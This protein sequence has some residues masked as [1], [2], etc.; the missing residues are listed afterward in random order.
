MRWKN[1]VREVRKG[2]VRVAAATTS[3]VFSMP[4][5]ATCRECHVGARA[6]AGKVTSDCA[7]CHRFH[8]G[9]DYWHDVL[10]AQMQPRG[11]K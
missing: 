7:T 3:P 8:A 9:R 1:G 4:D 11:K 6:V 5:I 2:L 10:Q